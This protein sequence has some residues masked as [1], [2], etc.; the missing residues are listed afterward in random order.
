MNVL[1]C[2]LTTQKEPPQFSTAAEVILDRGQ[3]V[4]RGRVEW[5]KG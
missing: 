5:R 1:V 4:G 3:T 2:S